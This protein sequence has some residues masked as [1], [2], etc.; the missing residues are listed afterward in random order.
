MQECLSLADLSSLVYFLEKAGAYTEWSTF[1]VL[2]S[3]ASP[4]TYTQALDQA[5]KVY[6]GQTLLLLYENS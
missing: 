6:Q 1:Q 3:R 5:R 2:N 4:W